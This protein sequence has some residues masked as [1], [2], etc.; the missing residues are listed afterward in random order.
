MKKKLFEQPI[1]I[2][3]TLALFL[4]CI[5]FSPIRAAS[6]PSSESTPLH[7]N[8]GAVFGVS[9]LSMVKMFTEKPPLG[10]HVS[11]KYQVITSPDQV[12][13]KTIS[14]ELDIVMIASNLGAKL[15][16]KGVPYTLAGAMVWGNLYVVSSVKL[17]GWEDLRGR[18]IF[19]HARGLTPD[20]VFQSLLRENGLEPQKDVT[21][22][23]LSG[24]P[25]AL[26][27]SFL[28][29]KSAVSIMPEPMV[30][31]VKLRKKDTNIV[32]DLQQE[33][34]KTTG[35]QHKGFPQGALLI[36]NELIEKH[37]EVVEA[38]LTEYEKS[39]AWMNANTEAAGKYAEELGIGM[40]AK[41]AAMGIPG[42]NLSYV[43]A[44]DAQKEL[45]TLFTTLHNY[46]PKAVGGKV[47][48][49]GLYYKR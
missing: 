5:F 27:M 10:D 32:L 23:Y 49:E 17:K 20:F 43:D 30:A 24:G 12:A 1:F 36:K 6:A 9:T 34:Q 44:A 7:L 26:A 2:L 40:K 4:A 42:C 45:N 21:L 14:G 38:F 37:P 48:D 19:M 3:F 31:K 33:W 18:T 8:I 35:S 16:N 29:G 47:P 46:N 28:G 41:P 22:K 25:Q 13:A 15:Y 11:A 39:I